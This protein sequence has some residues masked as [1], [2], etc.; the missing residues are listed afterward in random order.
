MM[1]S[2][3]DI[4]EMLSCNSD[5]LLQKKGFEAAKKIKHLSVLI[6][7]ME[8]KSVWE[9]CA[10]ILSEK[11]DDEL[12]PYLI[13]L[14]KWLQDMTWPGAYIIYDRLKNIPAENIEGPLDVCLSLACES[15][16]L[17]WKQIL[18]DF[19]KEY[20]MS[21]KRI[22]VRSCEANTQDQD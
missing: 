6:Q 19:K 13:P 22:D 5:E 11:S 18:T 8:D 14:L 4:L 15:H 21:G 7:P 3:D 16:D 9:N 2:I 20:D 17:T 10:K 12:L 1:C